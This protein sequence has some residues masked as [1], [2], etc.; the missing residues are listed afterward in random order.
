MT[1]FLRLGI[2]G[3]VSFAIHPTVAISR[4]GYPRLIMKVYEIQKS[5]SFCYSQ[6]EL[7]LSIFTN[8]FMEKPTFDSS[9]GA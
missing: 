6:Q 7:I 1:D 4:T 9:V 2:G 8:G 3:G 5:Q